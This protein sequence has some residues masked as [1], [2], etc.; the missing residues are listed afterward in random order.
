MQD[1]L[2]LRETIMFIIALENDSEIIIIY[3]N[4]SKNL[5]S[6]H[7]HYFSD[8]CSLSAPKCQT[9]KTLTH[10]QLSVSNQSCQTTPHR[11]HGDGLFLTRIS[12]CDRL[13]LSNVESQMNVANEHLS[14]TQDQWN[15]IFFTNES[16]FNH[17]SNS[18][19]RL[20]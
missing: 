4:V 8:K 15:Q 14:L 16:L 18:R 20:I 12:N 19:S 1:N 13:G 3:Q 17:Q 7:Q 6:E 10:S 5:G 2:M 11:F 9:S